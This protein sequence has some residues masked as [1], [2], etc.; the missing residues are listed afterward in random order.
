MATYL[1]RYSLWDL[2]HAPIKLDGIMKVKRCQDSL[3]AKT[4]L[5][6]HLMGKHKNYGHCDIH[7]V[8]MDGDLVG[9]MTKIFNL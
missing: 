5:C 7:G 9:M 4:K 6:R 3:Q 8:S 1:I 2:N